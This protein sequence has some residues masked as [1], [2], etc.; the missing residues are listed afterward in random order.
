[1]VELSIVSPVYQAEASVAPLVESIKRHASLV[2]EDF[3][4]ILVE[5]RGTD[6]SWERIVDECDK[7]TR[8]TGIRL[9]RNFG[10]HRAIAAGLEHSRG[11]QIIVMDCDLQDDPAY[12][13]DLVAASRDGYEIVFTEK[14]ERGHSASRNVAGRMFKGL[15]RWL[16]A[17]ENDGVEMSPSVG[18][19]S[20]ISRAALDAMNPGSDRNYRYLASLSYLGFDRTVIPTEHHERA[21]GSSSYDLRRLL[22]GAAEEITAN[23]YRLLHLS[24]AI[25]F[26]FVALSVVSIVVLLGLWLTQGFLAG[27]TSIMCLLLISTGL[28]LSSTGVIGLYLGRA[29]EQVRGRPPYAVSEIR[30][31]TRVR[32]GRPD[33][34][35]IG[36]RDGNA[37]LLA[38]RAESA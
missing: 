5:D 4:I 13:P 6:R 7:D 15:L 2:T 31:G 25:G 34:T 22:K 35:V 26:G 27:W 8:V 21:H 3:E 12:I 29:L 30:N 36:S 1:M 17:A 11:E 14:F 38:D 9:S 19:Y 28:I 18:N 20:L 32:P 37:T 24:I 16:S 10:Q 33:L 23:S